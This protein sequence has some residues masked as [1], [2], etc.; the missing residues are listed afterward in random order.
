MSTF[1]HSGGN[2]HV[3]TYTSDKGAVLNIIPVHIADFLAIGDNLL[4]INTVAD[5]HKLK[6]NSEADRDT[7]VGHINMALRASYIEYTINEKLIRGEFFNAN[8]ME[9]ELAPGGVLD[10]LIVVPAGSE[11]S[12][13]VAMTHGGNLLSEFFIDPTVTDTGTVQGYLSRNEKKQQLLLS[14][15]YLNP[16]MSSTGT[17][18]GQQ[19]NLGSAETSVSAAQGGA[20]TFILAE[21]S[22]LLRATNKSGYFIPVQRRMQFWEIP[23]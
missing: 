11:M 9:L 3:L 21:G 4:V 7:A 2:D 12:L 16:T 8:A 22:Y 23:A 17:K 14:S 6:F 13:F 19:F 10:T 1:T 18:K 15:L 5:S 20:P